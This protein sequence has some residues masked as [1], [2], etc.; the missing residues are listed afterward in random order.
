MSWYWSSDLIVVTGIFGSGVSWGG[1]AR[2]RGSTA[3]HRRRC[4][5]ECVSRIEALRRWSGLMKNE[6][7]DMTVLS[8]T[9]SFSR[10]MQGS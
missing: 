6:S 4:R 9:P 1:R 10:N 5:A 3:S 7:R 8:I 2:D